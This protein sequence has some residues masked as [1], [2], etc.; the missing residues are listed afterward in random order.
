MS[1]ADAAT[2]L[3]DELL[4]APS[5]TIAGR[6]S[7]VEGDALPGGAGRPICSVLQPVFIDGETY[8]GMLR[9]T[10]LAVRGFSAV[11]ASTR[12]DPRCARGSG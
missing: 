2:R 6:R 3:H 10:P 11:I 7:Q 12:N 8:D 1:I 4:P 9:D 5:P